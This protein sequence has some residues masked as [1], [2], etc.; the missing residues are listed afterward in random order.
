MKVPIKHSISD[1][2]KAAAARL[3]VSENAMQDFKIIKKSIDARK[4]DNVH[5]TYCVDVSPH[6]Q[7]IE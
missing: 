7:A 2:K 5:Y 3:R 1:V 6:I 4:K